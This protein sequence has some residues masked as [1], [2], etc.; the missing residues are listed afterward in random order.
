MWITIIWGIAK[1]CLDFILKPSN[2]AIAGVLCLLAFG[3]GWFKG[4]A[5]KER[6]WVARI[7]AEREKQAQ[8]VFRAD[9]EALETNRKLQEELDQS[10]AQINDLLIAAEKDANAGRV[11]LGGDSLKRINKGR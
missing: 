11:C 9:N 6:V 7:A 3:T 8:I 10:N 5:H 4:S 2:L 1:A